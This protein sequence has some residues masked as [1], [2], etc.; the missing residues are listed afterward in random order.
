LADFSDSKKILGKVW[1]D[2]ATDASNVEVEPLITASQLRDRFLFGL[3]LTSRIKDPLTGKYQQVSDTL[4]ND[5]IYGAISQI[6]TDFK[7]DI[8]P[9]QRKQKLP[10]DRTEYNNFGFMQ[11]D[12]TPVAS[13]EKLTVSPASGVDVYEVPKDWIETAYLVRGQVNIIPMGI[14]TISQGMLGGAEA[15]GAMFLTAIQFT[16]W[17]P[18]FWA[19]T[20]TTGYPD[21]QLPRVVNEIIGCVAAIEILGMLAAT[22]AQSTSTSLG[23]DGMSQSIATPGPTLFMTRIQQLE[24]KY[25][26]L[27]GR[28]R[29]FYGHNIFVGNV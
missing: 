20:Y 26:K 1:P 25:N 21:G 7:I 28:L 3:P 19:I 14:G 5:L 9:K 6:E 22:F 4:I 10:L 15:S 8:F 24:E 11:L 13:I 12:H 23:I 29:A 27:G 16:N 2:N 18:A 17:L